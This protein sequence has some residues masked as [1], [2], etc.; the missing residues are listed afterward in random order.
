MSPYETVEDIQTPSAKHT[1]RGKGFPKENQGIIS[2]R[3]NEV[4]D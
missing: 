1:V 4:R 2:G 3:G